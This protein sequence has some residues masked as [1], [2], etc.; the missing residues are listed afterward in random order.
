MSDLLRKS[1]G[2]LI[3]PRLRIQNANAISS[4][5]TWG[6]PSMT[7]FLGFMWALERKLNNRY[8][9]IFHAVGVVCHD[10]APQV[11]TGGF[12]KSFSLSRNPV[13]KDGKSASIVEEGR[14]HLD[15][16][17]VFAVDG[18]LLTAPVQ[19]QDQA[20]RDI[21][22]ILTSMRIAGGTILPASFSRAPLLWVID[23]DEE[24]QTRQF[25][26]ILRTLLPGF[27]LVER[28]DLLDNHYQ[29][30]VKQDTSTTR[31][32]AWLDLS[33]L[34]Y[35]AT[36]E[37]E[38][39]NT[40]TWEHDRSR[41]WIVPIPLGYAALTDVQ[42]PGAV[43]NARDTTTPF[44]FVEAMLGIGQWIGPHHLTDLHQMLWYAD[45]NEKTGVYRC[46]NDYAV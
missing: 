29:Q 2:V 8:P 22:D 4:P 46:R 7:A 36:W 28:S 10:F 16:S 19:D 20:L 35:Q 33:R 21:Q 40:V 26:S 13:G 3:L 31:L 6:F 25:R 23:D 9:L 34:N 17:L 38:E 43:L 27:C 11:S 15:L 37:D 5:M 12:T 39:K 44:R 1:D 18:G 42:E 24:K 41:E 32:D 30:L 45:Y 14:V